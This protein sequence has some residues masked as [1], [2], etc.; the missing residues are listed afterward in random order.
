MYRIEYFCP[1]SGIHNWQVLTSGW[2]WKTPEEFPS[3]EAAAMTCNSLLW[4]YH[5][6]RVIDPSGNVVYQV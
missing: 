6:A 5:S 1:R 2:I 3:F 4:R